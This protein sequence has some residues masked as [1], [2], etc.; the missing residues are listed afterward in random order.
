VPVERIVR[1]SVAIFRLDDLRIGINVQ[2][3]RRVVR[4]VACQPLPNAPDIVD[5]LINVRG[6]VIPVVS[7]RRRLGLP[8]KAPHPMQHLV[9]G[10][11]VSRPLAFAVDAAEGT[12]EASEL[13]VVASG[14]FLS[15]DQRMQG[16]LKFTD[17]LIFIHDLAAFFSLDE[18]VNLNAA[19]AAL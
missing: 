2:N 1:F 16:V 6:E 7:M 14:D 9:I 18:E 11:T 15:D 3:V 4:M 17:G 5:G 8:D 12:M 10:T 19:L 13:D